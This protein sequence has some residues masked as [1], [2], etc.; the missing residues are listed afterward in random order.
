MTMF[1]KESIKDQVIRLLRSGWYSTNQLVQ[2]IGA[3][4][5][6]RRLRDL[7]ADGYNILERKRPD[8][9]VERKIA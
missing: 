9:I 2:T 3:Q 6:D 7:R 5:A 4:S 8:G 1:T